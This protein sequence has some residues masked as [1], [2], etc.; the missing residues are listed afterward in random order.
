MTT[1]SSQSDNLSMGGTPVACDRGPGVRPIVPVV[2]NPFGPAR[3]PGASGLFLS[4]QA[5]M[6]STEISA[7][8][9]Q[10]SGKSPVVDGRGG[11]R[12]RRIAK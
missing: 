9:Q 6:P 1:S 3:P 5:T 4:G 11:D 12:P 2:A 7:R 10:W 8:R